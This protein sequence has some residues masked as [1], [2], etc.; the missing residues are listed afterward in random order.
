MNGER[1]FYLACREWHFQLAD[2]MTLCQVSLDIVGWVSLDVDCHH[3]CQHHDCHCTHKVHA[4]RSIR[5]LSLLRPQLFNAAPNTLFSL[6]LSHSRSFSLVLAR[7]LSLTHTFLGH[8]CAETHAHN[9]YV[10]RMHSLSL[11]LLSL[12]SPP[13]PPA[14]PMHALCLLLSLL[15]S[16]LSLDR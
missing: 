14:P 9:T 8:T 5:L 10:M 2:A 7:S 4:S 12:S 13:H 16:F 1:N 6:V 3:H 11:S 15:L